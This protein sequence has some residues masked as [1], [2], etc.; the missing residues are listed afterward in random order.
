MAIETVNP[1]TG[2]LV[3]R[4]EEIGSAEVESKLA[5]AAAAFGDWRETSFE[6][7]AGLMKN[8]ARVL[9]D[10]ARHHAEL[11]TLEMGKPITQSLSEVEKCAAVCEYYAEQVET[12]LAPRE[13]ESDA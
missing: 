4:Y 6:H 11:I 2:E 7:R 8:A 5:A 9:R 10:G 13:I 1:A 12:F 3:R